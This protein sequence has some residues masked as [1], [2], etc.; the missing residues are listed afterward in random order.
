MK[1]TVFCLLL[2]LSSGLVV[3]QDADNS[4]GKVIRLNFENFEGEGTKMEATFPLALLATAKPQIE[5]ALND[6]HEEHHVN[7]RDIWNAVK[8]SGPTE[9]VNID[10]HD[11]KIK[12]STTATHL[13][14]YVDQRQ[15]DAVFHVTLPLALGDALFGE[16]NSELNYDTIIEALLQMEGQDLVSIDSEDMKGRVWIE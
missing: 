16:E 5:R 4:Q 9:Y 7:F 2:I 1:P 3:A 12:V 15:E 13:K 6:I 11:A 8:D 14:V 10:S